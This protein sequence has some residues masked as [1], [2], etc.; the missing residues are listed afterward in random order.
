VQKSEGF[1]D[2]HP[3]GLAT[4]MN[5]F[6]FLSCGIIVLIGCSGVQQESPTTP[7]NQGTEATP[8]PQTSASGF[9][10]L[11]EQD[12]IRLN[13]RFPR[14]QQEVLLNAEYVDVFELGECLYGPVKSNSN[15]QGLSPIEK[16]K[17]QGCRVSRHVRVSDSE[18]RKELVEGILYSIG[19][20]GN[21]MACFEPRHAV[22]AIHKGE[23]IEL[24]ICF[25]CENFRGS[26]EHLPVTNF[27]GDIVE[28]WEK[29]SG[30]FS[31]A[32]EPLFERILS[33]AT[34]KHR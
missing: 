29:F 20:S 18:Q 31:P 16:N 5:T 34:S 33:K 10:P 6:V 11:N 4:A 8:M 3:I 26:P 27:A 14:R 2:T 17:F 21:G 15:N 19:S 23:R 25:E 7:S 30:G 12:L 22:R 32:V 9:P 1:K 24:V 28:P 13:E